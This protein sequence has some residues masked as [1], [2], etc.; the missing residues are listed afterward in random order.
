[1]RCIKVLLVTVF[2]GLSFAGYSQLD[3]CITPARIN[4]TYR[5]NFPT[6]LP[7]CGC[8]GITYRNEC[9]AYWMNG[10]NWWNSGICDGIGLDMYPNPSTQNVPINLTIQ[11]PENVFGNVDMRVVDMFGKTR[12]QNIFNNFNRMEFSLDITSLPLGIYN[13]VLV[14]GNGDSVVKR[15][16]KA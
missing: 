11:F 14:S 16:I 8:D 4:P 10:V 5:C 1:M 2:V 7:V 13:V 12:M 6:Y 15:F 9:E 3:P